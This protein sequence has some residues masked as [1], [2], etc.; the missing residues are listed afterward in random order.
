MRIYTKQLYYDRKHPNIGPLRPFGYVL[1]LLCGTGKLR[2]TEDGGSQLLDY[3]PISK[4]KTFR[5]RPHAWENSL[6]RSCCEASKR[7][8]GIYVLVVTKFIEENNT[9]AKRWLGEQCGYEA[10]WIPEALEITPRGLR[11]WETHGLRPNW[12]ARWRERGDLLSKCMARDRSR[13]CC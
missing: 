13:C 11:S 5:R 12:W 3:G 4:R 9:D 1:Y 10:V 7:R 8:K 6:E 2:S